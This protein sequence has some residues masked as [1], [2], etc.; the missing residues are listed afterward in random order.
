MNKSPFLL[1]ALLVSLTLAITAGAVEKKAGGGNPPT[2]PH[3]ITIFFANDVRGE[4]E[5]CG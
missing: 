2:G 5:P 4:T 3:E 1:L